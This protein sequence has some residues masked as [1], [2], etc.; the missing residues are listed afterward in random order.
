M[1]SC[2]A[3]LVAIARYPKVGLV[4]VTAAELWKTPGLG[5]RTGPRICANPRLARN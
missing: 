5:K 2:G 4:E 3:L 1:V